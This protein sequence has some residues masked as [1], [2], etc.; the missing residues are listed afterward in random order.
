MRIVRRQ[1]CEAK[2]C[3]FL[4]FDPN[5]SITTTQWV[6]DHQLARNFNNHY[7]STPETATALL[8]RFQWRDHA[9][10]HSSTIHK[11][12]VFTESDRRGLTIDV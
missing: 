9:P 7:H 5:S 11:S 6:R 10:Y 1:T 12:S 8:G 3:S 2:F 4:H